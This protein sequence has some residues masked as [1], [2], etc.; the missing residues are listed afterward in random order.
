MAQCASVFITAAEARTNPIR[1]RIIHDEACGIQ[2]VILDAV[3]IGLFEATVSDR[4]PMTKSTAPVTDVWTVD[5]ATDQF[6]IPNHSFSTGD[7]VTVSSSVALPSPLKTNAYYYVIYVDTDRIKL[8]TSFADAMSGRP[9]AVDVTS[10]ITVFTITSEGSGYIQPPSVTLSGGNPTTDARAKSYLAPWGSII[11]IANTTP[12]EGYNDTPSVQIVP[13]GSGASAGTISYNVVGISINNAGS[14]YHFGDIITVV[15][16]TGTAATAIITEVDNSGSIVAISLSNTG[17]YT[18]LPTASSASTTASPGG[19][20]SATVNLTFGIKSIAVANGGTGYTAPPRIVIQDGSGVNAIANAIVTGGSISSIVITNSGYGYV[21]VSSI[22][23]DSGTDATAIASMIPVGVGTI[24]IVNNSATYST[25]PSVTVS[26]VGSGAAAGL[27]YMKVVSCQL[28]GSGINYSKDDTLLIA[29]GSAT[30]NA[31]IRVVTVDSAGR[32]LTYTLENGGSYSALPGL[33]SN[34]V[35]GGTGTLAAFNLSFGVESINVSST[36][37]GYITPPNVIISAPIEG[38]TALVDATVVS[39]VVINFN[40]KNSGSG[41]ITI[42][43]VTISNGTGATAEATLSSTVV[44]NISVSNGGSGYSTANVIITGGGASVDATA[45][46]T[47]SGNAIVGISVIDGGIGYTSTPNVTIVGDGVNATAT[48]ILDPRTISS[49]TL[50]TAGSGYNTPPLVTLTGAATAK[51]TLQTTRIDKIVVTAQGSNYTADPTVYLI[52]GPNQTGSTPIP[53]I[54]VA[55]RGFSISSIVATDSGVGYDSVPVVS[56][57]APQYINGTQATATVAIGAGVGT[58][59]LSPYYSSRDYF[60]AWKNQSLSNEQLARPYVER[61]D[62]IIAYFTNLGYNINR[63][64]NT[65]TGN[66][67]SWKIQW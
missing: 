21:G 40:V 13:Q 53:P 32:I 44:G 45:T 52:P 51:S 16:G 60:K 55:Q 39:N 48:A 47:I 5:S 64:T 6:Y 46:A 50:L 38:T 9:V 28:T 24:S 25:A 58:F 2:S 37:S 15:G 22:I 33:E 31:W 18:T 3:K 54:M 26:P 61:M 12:G 57:T 27:V 30:E 7:T 14:N 49:I 67:F 43:T 42:P 36:G 62:T 4:T 59:I 11:A 19:G 66:T 35:N 1:D 10:G 65:S 17:N 63:V 56:I 20:T 34:P 8:A 41:Y 23:F 29:G